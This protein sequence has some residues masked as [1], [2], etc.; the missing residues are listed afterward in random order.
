MYTIVKPNSTQQSSGR[1]RGVSDIIIKNKI[2]HVVSV[3]IEHLE[4]RRIIFTSYS[5]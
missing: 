4:I 1:A 5:Y 3:K 2:Q